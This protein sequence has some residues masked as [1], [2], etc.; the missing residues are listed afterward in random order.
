MQ[1]IFSNQ[2]AMK[3]ELNKNGEIHKYYETKLLS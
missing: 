1:G 3:L 2:N